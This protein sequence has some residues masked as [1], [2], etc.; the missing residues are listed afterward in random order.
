M[1]TIKTKEIQ[2]FEKYD[3]E[4]L[5]FLKLKRALE[6]LKDEIRLINYQI[7]ILERVNND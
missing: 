6:I 1:K 4:K 3:F 2:I 7:D 5:K